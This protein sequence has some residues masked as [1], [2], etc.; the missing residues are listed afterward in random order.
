MVGKDVI[1]WPSSK[2]TA[3]ALESVGITSKHI[4]QYYGGIMPIYIMPS[5]TKI[6]L[7]L[8]EEI[9]IRE[10]EGSCQKVGW[11]FEYESI[12]GEKFTLKIPNDAH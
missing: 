8:H 1:P 3:S 2:I 5:E 11:N 4:K 10:L 9:A 7:E 6:L 12:Y